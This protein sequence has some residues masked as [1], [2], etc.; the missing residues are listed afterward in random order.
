MAARLVEPIRRHEAPPGRPAVVGAIAVGVLV[1]VLASATLPISRAAHM[2]SSSGGALYVVGIP[3][4]VVGLL[5]AVRRPDNAMGWC[6]LGAALFFSMTGVGGSYSVLDYR[7]HH[8]SLPLGGA[9]VLLQPSWAPAIFF[10]VLSFLLYPDGHFSSRLSKWMTW[11]VVAVGAVWMAGAFGIAIQAIAGHTV[12]IDRTGNLLAVDNPRGEWAW[13]AF[14]QLAYFLSIGA[15]T[16]VW[17]CQQVPR[18]R[19]AT[20]ELRHQM[21]WLLSGAGIAV[22]GGVLTPGTAG[23]WPSLV[24]TISLAALPISIGIG[25]TKFRLYDIDRVVSRTLSYAILTGVVVGVYI[26][27]VTLTTK[28]IGF[29]SSIGVAA[30]TLVAAALFNPV[31]KRA[32]RL[33]D[34]QFNRAR[35]DA[36]RTVSAFAT[37]LRDAVD[38]GTVK[39]DL[40]DVVHAAFEPVGASVWIRPQRPRG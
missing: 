39:T 5:L 17:F 9:A 27:V 2:S 7:V 25:V 21:K 16:V 11:L 38:P 12:H 36:E 19:R 20:D 13:W 31:R 28:A 24:G 6:L 1:V 34:R 26:G 23:F 10:F 35:Y 32:Q 18:Y 15:S 40:I 3:A 37:R 4:L 14:V 29:S 30:S 33:V 22:V 8:G